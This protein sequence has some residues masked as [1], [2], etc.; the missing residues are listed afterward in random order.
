MKVSQACVLIDFRETSVRFV[1]SSSYDNVTKVV[2]VRDGDSAGDREV[3]VRVLAVSPPALDGC[4][5]GRQT[6]YLF[7]FST[8]AL[9][10]SINKSSTA[11]QVNLSAMSSYLYS[12]SREDNP[13]WRESSP[14]WPR[15]TSAPAT[16]G[17]SRAPRRWG[18][19]RPSGEV[20]RMLMAVT[21]DHA[22]GQVLQ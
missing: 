21:G 11:E 2:P 13:S 18:R 5:Q 19:R 6:S 3:H 1:D 15:P 14:A 22:C 17:A 12:W 4:Y 20:M 7:Q 10:K 9:E 8:T 16:P